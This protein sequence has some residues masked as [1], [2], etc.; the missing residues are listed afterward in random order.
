MLLHQ[1]LDDE[2]DAAASPL[3]LPS[4]LSLLSQF[5]QYLEVVVRCTRKTEARSWRTL[6][7]H[8]PPARE[9]FE[10]SLQRGD[11]KTAGG[12]LLVLHTLE[13]EG[14]SGGEGEDD[15]DEGDEAAGQGGSK[16]L[17]GVGEA[18][19]TTSEQSVRLLGRALREGDWE[20]CRE[21]ARFLAAI[22]ESG[23]ALRQAM[24]L[25]D[26]P[27]PPAQSTPTLVSV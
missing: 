27:L 14:S 26:L 2:A 12:Y 19:A 1:V 6:F 16:R 13:E 17:K 22:D 10:L 25:L 4:V 8:L 15:D 21:L 9:L 18:G 20:L 7:A 11:L 5:P 24:R 3:V 23:E